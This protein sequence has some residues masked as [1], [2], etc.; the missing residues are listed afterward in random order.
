MTITNNLCLILMT[1]ITYEGIQFHISFILGKY[2]REHK[3]KGNWWKGLAR[4][5]GKM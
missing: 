3:V 4:R 2:L 5:K 1:G